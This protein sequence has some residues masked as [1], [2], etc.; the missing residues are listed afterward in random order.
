MTRD[1]QRDETS[2]SLSV[3]MSASRC[4]LLTTTYSIGLVFVFDEGH[5][6]NPLNS[7][8]VRGSLYSTVGPSFEGQRQAGMIG[9]SDSEGRGLGRL[10][11]PSIP[12]N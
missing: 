11:S 3:F 5:Q 9:Y 8:K 4:R 1:P 7:K 2:L 6:A 10:W 12:V